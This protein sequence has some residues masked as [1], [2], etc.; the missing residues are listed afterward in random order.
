MKSP[1]P[2]TAENEFNWRNVQAPENGKKANQIAADD[3]SG[4]VVVE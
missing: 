2:V 4:Q 3:R 1:L